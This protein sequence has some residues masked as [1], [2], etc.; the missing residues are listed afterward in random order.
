[1]I[2]ISKSIVFN[3][4]LD[5]TDLYKWTTTGQLYNTKTMR[6]IKKTVNEQII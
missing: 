2:I 6:E 3:W 1:M 5:F 4:K